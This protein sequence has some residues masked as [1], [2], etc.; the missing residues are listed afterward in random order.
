MVDTYALFQIGDAAEGAGDFARAHSAFERGAALG[1]VACLSR[2]AYLFDT[3]KGVDVDKAVAMRLYQRAWRKEHDSV[4]GSN[5]AV[6]YRER[7]QWGQMFRWWQRVAATGDGSAQLEMAKCYLRGRG[8]TRN[9]QSA[10]RCLASAEGSAYISEYER[11][12]A[13]RLRRKLRPKAVST[14]QT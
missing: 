7:K 5:I 14:E 11:H 3:G 9:T 1:D 2:L 12:L 13:R 6:L 10:L 4:A 8:V